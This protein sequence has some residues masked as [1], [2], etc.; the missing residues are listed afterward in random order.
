MF[1]T[2]ALSVY[3]LEG[4]TLVKRL[5]GSILISS[6]VVCH[7]PLT[8]NAEDTDVSKVPCPGKYCRSDTKL[9]VI[10]TLGIPGISD[11][12]FKDRKDFLK[13]DTWGTFE[14]DQRGA[15]SHEFTSNEICYI[16]EG[17]FKVTPDDSAAKLVPFGDLTPV[18][19]VGGD[20][21][22]FPKGLKS[23]WNV[24]E[25]VRGHVFRY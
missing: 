14:S 21:V 23:Q 24:E 9:N 8:A 17:K 19:V 7:P 15:S 1:L 13:V 6:S 3:K 25:P 2:L 10:H 22:V 11:R 12:K 18:S 5:V 20:F 4:L 16:D